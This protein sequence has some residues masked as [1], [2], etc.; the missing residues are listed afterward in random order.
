MSPGIGQAARRGFTLVELL[1][2]VAIGLFLMAVM[3]AVYVGSKTSFVAQESGSRLQENGRFAMDTLTQDLRMSGFRG[4]SAQQATGGSGSPLAVPAVDNT[5]NTPDGLLYNFGQPIWGSHHNGSAWSPALAAPLTGLSPAAGGDVLVIRRPNGTAWS[6]IAEMADTTAPLTVT[7]TAQFAKGDL[8]MV[9]DCAGASVLQATNDGPGA[10]GSL[11]HQTAVAGLV[12]G[13]ARDALARIF[14]H[15]AV[16]W[17]MQTLIYYLAAS[18]RQSGQT[19]L[20]LYRHPTYDGSAQRSE[21][22]TGVERMAL[23]FGIDNDG[24]DAA[25]RLVAP[26]S[27]TDWGR[28][29]NARVELLLVS[30][31]SSTSTAQPYTFAGSTVTPTDGKPRAVMSTLVALRNTL[32]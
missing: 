10:A 21:L 29:V 25:D 4:C 2:G 20:W 26:G 18:E 11:Q 7:A 23:T 28:V 16:V 6:L 22:I 13:V 17:R 19:A 30:Q 12:P 24:D 3:G 1:V 32:P 31:G 14:A 5:L 27:V 8:L 15:D 9:A